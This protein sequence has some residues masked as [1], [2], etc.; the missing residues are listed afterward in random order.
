MIMNSHTSADS[1]HELSQK[2][3]R[4][5]DNDSATKNSL[6]NVLDDS[7]FRDVKTN[8]NRALL[9]R[10]ALRP[11]YTQS[12]VMGSE[13]DELN[14]SEWRSASI[15]I[16]NGLRDLTNTNMGAVVYDDYPMGIAHLH[17]QTCVV[18]QSRNAVAH[19]MNEGYT[20]VGSP[21]EARVVGQVNPESKSNTKLLPID[22]C[23]AASK[24][25]AEYAPH[26]ALQRTVNTAKIQLTR[27]GRVMQ[28]SDI[29][30][31]NVDSARTCELHVDMTPNTN[32][33]STVENTSEPIVCSQADKC[34]TQSSTSNSHEQSAHVPYDIDWSIHTHKTAC[35]NGLEEHVQINK[36]GTNSSACH[37]K[38]KNDIAHFDCS[39]KD[40]EDH[41]LTHTQAHAYS[42]RAHTRPH[43][44]EHR[45]SR[46]RGVNVNVITEHVPIAPSMCAIDDIVH[47]AAAETTTSSKP[48]NVAGHSDRSGVQEWVGGWP[49]VESK[50]SSSMSV[51]DVRSVVGMASAMPTVSPISHN[52]M[53]G[54]DATHS[55]THQE[56]EN[57]RMFSIKDLWEGEP[58]PAD[59]NEVAS[60][61]FPELTK[62]VRR[63]YVGQQQLSISPS[64][65]GE[66]KMNP[67][68]LSGTDNDCRSKSP[69]GLADK[70]DEERDLKTS[71]V[72]SWDEANLESS[73]HY[74]LIQQL[75]SLQ[76]NVKRETLSN[77]TNNHSHKKKQQEE[78]QRLLKAKYSF[79]RPSLH[80]KEGRK[81]YVTNT[82]YE[83]VCQR[84]MHS[85]TLGVYR[86]Y[87]RKAILHELGGWGRGRIGRGTYPENVLDGYISP[88]QSKS[89]NEERTVKGVVD[90]NKRKAIKSE[91]KNTGVVKPQDDE[92]AAYRPVPVP[93]PTELRRTLRTLESELAYSYEYYAGAYSTTHIHT[94]EENVSAY[95]YES[96]QHEN[97][98][99]KS[100]DS[101]DVVECAMRAIL[102]NNNPYPNIERTTSQHSLSPLSPLVNT[103][104]SASETTHASPHDSIHDGTKNIL[105]SDTDI[106]T[107]VGGS[108]QAT[109]QSPIMYDDPLLLRESAMAYAL[110]KAPIKVD[111]EDLAIMR[112]LALR[113]PNLLV[114]NCDDVLNDGTTNTV[115]TPIHTHHHTS[116]S[117]QT[118]AN[119]TTLIPQ[120]K[121][122]ET[123]NTH[124][125]VQHAAWTA[126]NSG[127]DDT[128]THPEP[129]AITD[130]EVTE[131]LRDASKNGSINAADDGSQTNTDTLNNT[132]QILNNADLSVTISSTNDCHDVSGTTLLPRK[133]TETST[134][135]DT[136]IN[137]DDASYSCEDFTSHG[138]NTIVN[139]QSI[140]NKRPAKE[141]KI[142]R[143]VEKKK[144]RRAHLYNIS[145]VDVSLFTLACPGPGSIILYEKPLEGEDATRPKMREHI[146]GSARTEGYYTLTR[147][148]KKDRIDLIH[149]PKVKPAKTS[150]AAIRSN[151]RRE[152]RANSRKQTSVGE[153]ANSQQINDLVKR[154]K[155]LKF[156]KSAIH[157]VGLYAL[158]PIN[159]GD[160]VIEYVGEIV[161]QHVA[162]KREK[163]YE[164]QGVG[165]SY[166]FRVDPEHI[167]DATRMGNMARFINHRCEPNSV[168][169]IIT[170]KG[171]PRICIYAKDAIEIGEEITYDYKFP[172]EDEKIVCLCGS[173]N[174]R[175]F[176]N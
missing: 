68:H 124:T 59:K 26:E 13:F 100:V 115:T 97:G 57:D 64:L 47:A 111:D 145:A 168:A 171:E 96:S 42:Q 74:Q 154:H 65:S 7:T 45:N 93:S 126:S 159:A 86:K 118:N 11:T 155:R 78:Q 15:K 61:C 79:S 44:S 28:N 133:T 29:P 172:E 132:S 22:I 166:L 27:S 136:S 110:G 98:G 127:S 71:S 131:D 1:K 122:R 50:R 139:A 10:D 143:L 75:Q 123:V 120:L 52:S 33:I 4:V 18:D 69:I 91:K 38:R 113:Y 23:D 134:T 20:I 70:S 117:E 149:I 94:T 92:R 101:A 130:S 176:L 51:P 63:H 66:D 135:T 46:L 3:G 158:E 40:D 148:E 53:S 60:N 25:G 39:E 129:T 5:I 102:C 174:C 67:H 90:T 112:E 87:V 170:L 99:S 161:R 9:K 76:E 35:P 32:G 17:D 80:K 16:E 72:S 162:E 21:P 108:A 160:M 56:Q 83:Q 104:E 116:E 146:S 6:V 19:D 157:S 81:D 164:E 167:I 37:T 128:E 142:D 55:P 88:V 121:K 36:Q 54:K 156:G 41:I 49:R 8:V 95:E 58:L 106:C 48:G 12:S 73:D 140:N 109:A 24:I 165:S 103:R 77:S 175:G 150:A 43:E 114:D 14:D 31:D 141:S 125:G 152:H 138:K 105:H 119:T 62:K 147:K 85:A 89:S 173:I 169:K 30:T 153:E 34:S 144:R 151:T 2:E 84:L 163:E 137:R 107:H 82:A